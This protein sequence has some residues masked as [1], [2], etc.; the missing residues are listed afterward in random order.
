MGISAYGKCP[1]NGII[2]GMR[3][4]QFIRS[5]TNTVKAKITIVVGND[6]FSPKRNHSARQVFMSD[7]TMY[8]AGKTI[9]AVL[10]IDSRTNE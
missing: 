6:G 7:G 1:G 10:A 5:G 4:D 9:S 2:A 3:N 8:V